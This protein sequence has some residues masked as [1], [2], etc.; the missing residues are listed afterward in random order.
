MI[1]LQNWM[2]FFCLNFVWFCLWWSD[3][4]VENR[5]C[6]RMNAV[7][8]NLYLCHV[9]I[10]HILFQFICLLFFFLFFFLLP[11]RNNSNN[12]NTEQS[13]STS[14]R[15]TMLSS[16]ASSSSSSSSTSVTS[17]PT[18]TEESIQSTSVNGGDSEVTNSASTEPTYSNSDEITIKLKYLNDDLKIV[19]A[20][21]NEPIGDFKK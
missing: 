18:T 21:T 19:K 5:N 16:L 3:L 4:F 9:H 17:M 15:D 8:I 11:Y 10:F 12:T 2:F 1:I 20:R 6:D 14:T 13:S 7:S